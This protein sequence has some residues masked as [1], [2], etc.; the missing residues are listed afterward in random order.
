MRNQLFVF[1]LCCLLVVLTSCATIVKGNHDT[2][3]FRSEPTGAK[4]TK[5][6]KEIGITP[7]EVKLF[8]KNYYEFEISADEYETKKVTV[9]SLYYGAAA[10]GNIFSFPIIG[11]IVDIANG[12]AF[13]LRPND[14][15]VRLNKK[16]K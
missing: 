1:V 15:Y 8:T 16:N 10:L 6:G 2:I 13:M 7:C 3:S 12:S 14:V 4:V 5:D 9:E 11:H